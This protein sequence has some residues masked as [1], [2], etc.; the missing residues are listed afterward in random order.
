MEDGFSVSAA[1]C[2]TWPRS[3]V[4]S[5]RSTQWGLAQYHC[6][7]VPFRVMIFAV[8]YAALPWCAS[9]GKEKIETPIPRATINR[10]PRFTSH[11]L[12]GGTGP[13]SLGW[14]RLQLYKLDAILRRALA[15]V[16][17]ASTECVTR[18]SEM[19]SHPC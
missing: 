19:L 5:S 1:H 18:I 9:S 7:T 2:T 4:T 13:T 3:S 11:L 17:C 16:K 12:F 8:S 14:G 6:V 10:N 15:T